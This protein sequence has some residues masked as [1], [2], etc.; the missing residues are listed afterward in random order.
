MTIEQVLTVVIARDE[1]AEAVRPEPYRGVGL[2]VGPA[3]ASR[4]K[5]SG[6]LPPD[7]LLARF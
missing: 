7:G 3:L 5:M 1:G 6:L 2:V 4:A